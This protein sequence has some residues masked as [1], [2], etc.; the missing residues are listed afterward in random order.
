MSELDIDAMKL[1][2]AGGV[3]FMVNQT[4][5]VSMYSNEGVQFLR[6]RRL[7][8]EQS[9][10]FDRSKQRVI[11]LERCCFLMP[12]KHPQS[13]TIFW[14][15][16]KKAIEQ[17]AGTISIVPARDNTV[18]PIVIAREQASKKQ[19]FKLLIETNKFPRSFRRSSIHE[20]QL[21]EFLDLSDTITLHS[22]L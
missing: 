10:S 17:R 12:T 11:S 13:C 20:F 5:Q 4:N 2:L 15:V 3:V 7:W 18:C 21:T 22:S 16:T 19:N 6:N 1:T 14:I 9:N 8:L